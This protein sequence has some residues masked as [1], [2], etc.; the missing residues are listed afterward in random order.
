MAGRMRSYESVAFGNGMRYC[1]KE[2]IVYQED[3]SLSIEYGDGY[4]ENYLRYEHSPIAKE[5]NEFRTNIA[6]KYC[7]CIL[8]IGIGCG[9]FIKSLG[10]NTMCYGY[11]INPHGVEWLKKRGSYVNPY[12]DIPKEVDGITLWDV[13]EHLPNSDDLFGILP[14]SMIVITSLPIFEDVT[15]VMESKHFKKNEHYTYFERRG[16]EKYMSDMGFKLLEVT[17]KETKI[18]RESIKTFVFEKVS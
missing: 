5:L 4:W 1:F 14:L 9:T 15:K 8:D 7:S 18:G 13:L 3:T 11:D 12:E 6:T 2:G 10:I 16:L 17:N